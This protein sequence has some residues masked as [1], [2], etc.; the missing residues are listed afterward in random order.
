[1]IPNERN[2]IN[3]H[4]NFIPFYLL[5]PF[6]IIASYRSDF[7]FII[8]VW[9]EILIGEGFISNGFILLITFESGPSNSQKTIADVMTAALT[10]LSRLLIFVAN[11]CWPFISIYYLVISKGNCSLG[12]FQNSFVLFNDIDWSLCRGRRWLL[13]RSKI[14]YI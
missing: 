5:V 11:N 10:H 3:I 2:E 1:M 13:C 4:I 7:F 8:Y 12:R 14:T 6:R 9:E